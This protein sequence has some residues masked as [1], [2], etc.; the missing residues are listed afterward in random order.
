MRVED[1][2]IGAYGMNIIVSFTVLVLAIAAGFTVTYPNPPVAAL[3]VVCVVIAAGFPVVFQPISWSVWSGIDVAM[4]R[5]EGSDRPVPQHPV[6][7]RAPASER[8]ISSDAVGSS[9]GSVDAS[10]AALDIRTWDVMAAARL[11]KPEQGGS[12]GSGGGSTP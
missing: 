11:R 8:V 12:E 1:Q 9:P 10:F 2:W 3:T 7:P 6:P 5:P 4:R